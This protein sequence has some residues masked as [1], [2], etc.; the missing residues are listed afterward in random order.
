MET[1]EWLPGI[2]IITQPSPNLLSLISVHM[3]INEMVQKHKESATRRIHNDKE[4][5]A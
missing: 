4:K 5:G 2:E 3:F 1:S